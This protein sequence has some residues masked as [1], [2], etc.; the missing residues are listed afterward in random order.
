MM[1][2]RVERRHNPD[3]RR[4]RFFFQTLWSAVNLDLFTLLESPAIVGGLKTGVFSE[5]L[6]AIR[7]PF[8]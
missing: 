5:F 1:A 6:L 4:P 2:S 8:L 7:Q 3:F